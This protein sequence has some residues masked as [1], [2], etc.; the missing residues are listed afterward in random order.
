M[1]PL[2]EADLVHGEFICKAFESH[3][4]KRNEI[5]AGKQVKPPTMQTGYRI[6]RK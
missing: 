1:V 2:H 4:N 5:Y 6:G 3:L